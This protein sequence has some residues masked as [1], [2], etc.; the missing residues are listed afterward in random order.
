MNVGGNRVIDI[1][2]HLINLDEWKKHLTW[3]DCHEGLQRL[4]EVNPQEARIIVRKYSVNPV[5][6]MPLS[7]PRYIGF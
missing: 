5:H 6:E 1:P 3:Q 7:I 4:S 2:P